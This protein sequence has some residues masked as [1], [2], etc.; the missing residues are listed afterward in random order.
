MLLSVAAGFVHSANFLLLRFCQ[1]KK[2]NKRQGKKNKKENSCS[3]EHL[4]NSLEQGIGGAL[5]LL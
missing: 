1:P 5:L 4:K 3:G 2:K